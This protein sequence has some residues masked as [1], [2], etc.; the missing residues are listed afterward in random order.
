MINK[1]P[2]IYLAGPDVFFPNPHDVANKKKQICEQYGFEGVFPLDADIKAKADETPFDIAQKISLSN[3]DLMDSCD[4]IIANATPFRGASTDVGTAYEVGYMRAKGK[5]ALG[6]TNIT[7]EYKD[8]VEGYYNSIKAMPNP[9]DPD[10]INHTDI[11]DFGL[12]ENLMIEIAINSSNATLIRQTV[13]KGEELSDLEA[14][15][16]CVLQ[17]SNIIK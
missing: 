15:K 12:A 7:A 4:L 14:F 11:E 2:R 10:Q 5:P 1:T 6:Y 8:R 3:E 9:M 16:K 17:A 13:A